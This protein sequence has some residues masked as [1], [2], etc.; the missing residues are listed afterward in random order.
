MEKVDMSYLEE[1]S[2]G[3]AAF[4]IEMVE[5]FKDQVPEFI[6]GFNTYYE[7][8]N[9][10]NLGKLAHKAK[11]SVAVVG[12]NNLATD[13]KSIELLSR[14][15]KDVESYAAYIDNFEKVCNQALIDL[16]III[17]ELNE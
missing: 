14:D 13:L 8:S 3:D 9:W 5:I 2:G 6:Q 12:L 4:I 17:K 10:D 1:L 11:S 15:V 16:D 7:N